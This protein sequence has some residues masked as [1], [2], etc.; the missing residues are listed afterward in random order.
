MVFLMYFS[1]DVYSYFLDKIKETRL[2]LCKKEPRTINLNNL[3]NFYTEF[4][5]LLKLAN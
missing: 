1:T 5:L 3:S 4:I 2:L